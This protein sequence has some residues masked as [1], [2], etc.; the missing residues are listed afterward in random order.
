MRVKIILKEDQD[1]LFEACA[2]NADELDR[3][4]KE[5]RKKMR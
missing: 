5:M 1:T 2:K 4:F 3:H